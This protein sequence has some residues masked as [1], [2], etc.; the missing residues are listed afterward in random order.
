MMISEKCET[1]EQIPGWAAAAID[2][3]RMIVA[4]CAKQLRVPLWGKDGCAGAFMAGDGAPSTPKQELGLAAIMVETVAGHF[5]RIAK[6]S[7]DI[8]D[9]LYELTSETLVFRSLF[10]A[11][12]LAIQSTASR[13][14]ARK[15]HKENYELVEFAVKYWKDNIDPAMS[16]E[17]AADLLIAQVPL[18]HKKLAEVV[19]S[20]K[21]K[22]SH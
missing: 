4:N 18:S 21:K 15:R 22:H 16:A 6:G 19:S 5:R 12:R 7:N 14:M 3:A 20:E 9:S 1:G 17:K 2:E 10:T 11:V 13:S 8:P